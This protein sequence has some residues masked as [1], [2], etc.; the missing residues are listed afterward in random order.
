MRTTKGGE[1]RGDQEAPTPNS[2]EAIAATRQ[3]LCNHV[4]AVAVEL[5]LLLDNQKKLSARVTSTESELKD[6]RSSLK[7]LEGQGQP[8]NA[9]VWEL[10][11]QVEEAEG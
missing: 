2:H 6:L 4:D 7:E 8:L 1:A 10:E 11:H 9:K 5:G 3:D